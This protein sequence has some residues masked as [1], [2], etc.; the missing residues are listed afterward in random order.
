MS[1]SCVSPI[2]TLVIR[3]RVPLDNP[4]WSQFK[5]LDLFISAKILCPNEVTFTDCEGQEVVMSFGKLPFNLL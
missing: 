4:S 1:L 2:K 3:F 5:T